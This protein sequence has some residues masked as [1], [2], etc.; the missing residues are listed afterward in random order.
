MAGDNR[1][2]GYEFTESFNAPGGRFRGK[3]KVG[4]GLQTGREF[5]VLELSTK[6]DDREADGIRKQ[7]AAGKE[8]YANL[9][10][11]I[12][13]VQ[14][15]AELLRRMLKVGQLIEERIDAKAG[16]VV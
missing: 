10:T 15:L 9:G 12:N 3:V 16:A 8:P 5:V 1:D 14:A 11:S 2:T 6:L 4:R 7:V 13:D